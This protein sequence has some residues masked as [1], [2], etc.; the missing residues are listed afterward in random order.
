MQS[1]KEPPELRKIGRME[2]WKDGIGA[3]TGAFSMAIGKMK[4]H[5]LRE[6]TH[7]RRTC[8]SATDSRACPAFQSSSLPNPA[9]LGSPLLRLGQ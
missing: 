5:A 3:S 4:H 7:V 9:V 8:E 1:E 6:L 2:D